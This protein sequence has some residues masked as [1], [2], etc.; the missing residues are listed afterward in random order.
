MD[1]RKGFVSLTGLNRSLGA[2]TLSIIAF[3]SEE[4][5]MS[6]YIN[7]RRVLDV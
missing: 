4:R 5:L 6:Y 3:R 7:I 1:Q 2:F